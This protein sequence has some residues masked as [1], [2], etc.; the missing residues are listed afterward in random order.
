MIE[1]EK[2]EEFDV[3][4]FFDAFCIGFFKACVLGAVFCAGIYVGVAVIDSGDS[5]PHTQYEK[6]IN[7]KTGPDHFLDGKVN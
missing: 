7:P 1:T 3:V 2:G 6:V 5:K 4:K